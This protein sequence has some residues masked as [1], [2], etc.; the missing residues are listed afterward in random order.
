MVLLDYFKSFGATYQGLL[1]AK[2][3][4]VA[5]STITTRFY[6]LYQGKSNNLRYANL[7]LMSIFHIVPL[8]TMS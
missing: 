6:E 8:P 7:L 1:C 5:F 2:L 3:I 4:S